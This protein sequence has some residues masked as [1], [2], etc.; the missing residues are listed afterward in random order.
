MIELE[1]NFRQFLDQNF[2]FVE[3]KFDGA[4][5]IY[6]SPILKLRIVRDRNTE[7]YMDISPLDNPQ[8][9][10]DWIIMGDLRSYMLDNDDYLKGSDFLEVSTF[11]KEN[12]KQI[13]SLLDTNYE[14]VKKAL[15]E[16]GRHRADLLFG[17]IK[18]QDSENKGKP[19]D[20][21][22]QQSKKPWWKF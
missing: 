1:P 17:P 18:G 19:A 20:E 7:L 3:S 12:N 2:D 13:L 10:S 15:K 16:R 8:Q 22:K 6:F 21:S 9:P 14:N 11:F 5:D 4:V